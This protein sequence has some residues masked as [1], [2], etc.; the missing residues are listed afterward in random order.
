M[1][2]GYSLLFTLPAESIA[3]LKLGLQNMLVVQAGP[4]TKHA[5]SNTTDCSLSAAKNVVFL[6][7]GSGSSS[8]AAAAQDASITRGNSRRNSRRGRSVEL[9][10]YGVVNGQV[11]LTTGHLG[12]AFGGR[13]AGMLSKSDVRATVLPGVP[14][15]NCCQD[16]FCF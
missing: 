16:N 4:G 9:V 1:T 3:E 13:H 10:V 6:G 11:R 5:A 7:S 15:K 12:V 8:Q 14:G 2:S